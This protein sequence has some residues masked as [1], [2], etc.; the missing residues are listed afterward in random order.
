MMRTH[1]EAVGCKGSAR[2]FPRYYRRMHKEPVEI[3]VADESDLRTI[4]DP[5]GATTNYQSFWV[6]LPG[7]VAKRRDSVLAALQDQGISCRRG[8]MASHL[9]P[10]YADV[11]LRVPLP[12]TERITRGSLIL[13]LFH[14]M[15]TSDQDRV[16]DALR[17]QLH[18]R[19]RRV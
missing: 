11:K 10:A 1:H 19:R 12:V 3:K 15:S 5:I 8:I 17:Q 13:P 9:E 16:V 7:R 18:E 14:A 4:R 6:Q 2:R